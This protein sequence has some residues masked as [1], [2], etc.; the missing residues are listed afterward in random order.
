MFTSQEM[1]KYILKT[2]RDFEILN[3]CKKLQKLKLSE[4][5]KDLV[6]LIKTQLE[7]DWRKHLINKLNCLFKKYN[8]N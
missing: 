7:R 1:K 6:A 5:D 3:S 2:K 4:K 8:K